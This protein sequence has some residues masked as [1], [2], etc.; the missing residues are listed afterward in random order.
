MTKANEREKGA[1]KRK[2]KR[3]RSDMKKVDEYVLGPKDYEEIPEL[4]EEW[5]K[6]ATL[7]IGGVPISRGRPKSKDPKQAVSL[8]LDRDVVAHYRRT[9][10][11]WQSRINALLRKAAKL[12]K[13]KKR[14]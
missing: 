1:T 14:A 9:G 12:P 2:S 6:K 13:E 8:R 3:G 5:F 11:D 10:R 4:T 7:H